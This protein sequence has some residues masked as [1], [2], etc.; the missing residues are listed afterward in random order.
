MDALI[1][2][3]LFYQDK[4]KEYHDKMLRYRQKIISLLRSTPSS[5]VY[6]VRL[7]PRTRSGILKKDVPDEIWQKYSTTT[8]YDV[9]LV[10]KRDTR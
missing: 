2:K 5:L 10:K 1:E 7:D 4:N 3:Y 9:L 6:D 8:S